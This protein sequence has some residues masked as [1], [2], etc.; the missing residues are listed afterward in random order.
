MNLYSSHWF[1]PSFAVTISS[2]IMANKSYSNFL[3]N[4][5]NPLF[6]HASES[7]SQV[8][9]FPPSNGRNYHSWTRTMKLALFATRTNW[10]MSMDYGSIP[11]PYFHWC[12]IRSMQ[13]GLARGVMWWF[14]HGF[15][16]WFRT[17]CCNPSVHRSSFGSNLQRGYSQNLWSGTEHLSYASRYTNCHWV[18]HWIRILIE[19]KIISSLLLVPCVWFWRKSL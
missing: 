7:P 18:F 19:W 3:T 8:L 12:Q 5:S 10:R 15:I 11:V 14:L 2:K 1:F 13:L 4:P 6:F 9:V 16:V 17:L